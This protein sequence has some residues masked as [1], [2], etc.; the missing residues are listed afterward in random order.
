MII[1]EAALLEAL[2]SLSSPVRSM[3]VGETTGCGT[4]AAQE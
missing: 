3:T 1:G 4:A 2:L